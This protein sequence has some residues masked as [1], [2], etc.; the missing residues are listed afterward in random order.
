MGNLTDPLTRALG[1]IE[2]YRNNGKSYG[3]ASLVDGG[4]GSFIVVATAA[5]CLFDWEDKIFYNPVYFIPFNGK[6]RKRIK[7]K[8]AVIPNGWI[9][10]AIVD[11]DT[12][13]VV[14]EIDEVMEKGY[15]VQFKLEKGL[16][17]KVYGFRDSI[18]KNN[19]PYISTGKAELDLQYS[20]TLQGISSKGKGG[21]S[22]GPWLIEKNGA[23]IQN[24]LTSMSL[25]S[26]KN[27]LWGPYWGE[28][29]KI[30][31]EV[32]VGIID[33]HSDVFIYDY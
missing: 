4:N 13:F 22:G 1:K 26:K 9:K 16:E 14:C 12:A 25:K 23:Y 31:Y 8:R 20:S 6:S 30:A 32:A 24:S 5:H 3:S 18:F 15:P 7:A 11:Y 10:D 29:I 2:F 19:K 28:T 17:Y 27:M 21:M 33:K